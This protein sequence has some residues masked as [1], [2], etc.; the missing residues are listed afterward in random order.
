MRENRG[1]AAVIQNPY[2]TR[3][4]SA[5]GQLVASEQHGGAVAGPNQSEKELRSQRLLVVDRS[6]GAPEKFALPAGKE[7]TRTT[8]TAADALAAP[9]EIARPLAA[10]V[11]VTGDHEN[12]VP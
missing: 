6:P 2:E 3:V 10:M 7:R 12:P 4:M 1:R 9:H 11:D 8:R 5:V